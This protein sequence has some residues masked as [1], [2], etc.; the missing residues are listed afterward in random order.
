M[1]LATI[2]T[3]INQLLCQENRCGRSYLNTFK[4]CPKTDNCMQPASSKEVLQLPKHKN[5]W[6]IPTVFQNSESVQAPLRRQAI[7]LEDTAP[8]SNWEQKFNL[9]SFW[10]W[11]TEFPSS[12]TVQ[13]DHLSLP[14]HL[15]QRKACFA[16]RGS[17]PVVNMPSRFKISTFHCC[18]RSIPGEDWPE[19]KWLR[20]STFQRLYL[21]IQV[22]SRLE[23]MRPDSSGSIHPKFLSLISSACYVSLWILK[24]SH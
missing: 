13:R 11:W 19:G 5:N 14:F 12:L 9:S 10:S 6:Q 16:W 18:K 15:G 24:I 1:Q 17:A 20:S 21:Q 8:E 2:L 4:C 22:L 23:T 3:H 7:L